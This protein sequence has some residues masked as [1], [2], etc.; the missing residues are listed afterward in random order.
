MMYC[1]ACK[2]ENPNSATEC[3]NCGADLNLVK[4]IFCNSCLAENRK[5]A[6]H[7][8]DCGADLQATRKKFSEELTERAL[9]A[10]RRVYGLVS[11]AIASAFF[12]LGCAVLFPQIFFHKL[13]FYSGLLIVFAAARYC[14][15]RLADS[16]ND[17]SV[18]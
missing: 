4:V 14:G 9:T 15:L 18:R 1:L 13:A 2:Q 17:T 10:N 12:G 3:S 11:G 6:T 16:I 5:A 8:I 7:C